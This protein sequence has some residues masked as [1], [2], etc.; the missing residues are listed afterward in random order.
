MTFACVSRI[1]IHVLNQCCCVIHSLCC[2]WTRS[3][4]FYLLRLRF[5]HAYLADLSLRLFLWQLLS[6]WWVCSLYLSLLQL[7]WSNLCLSSSIWFSLCDVDPLVFYLVLHRFYTLPLVHCWPW[8]NVCYV[9]GR[10]AHAQKV[11]RSNRPQ[12]VSKGQRG[13]SAI[14]IAK[15]ANHFAKRGTSKLCFLFFFFVHL[16]G[17]SRCLT[18]ALIGRSHSV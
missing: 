10:W 14:D 15:G 8:L 18:S 17:I 5:W 11:A 7:I 16:F 12:S 4:V 6:P 9:D 13:A 1:S 2:Y 3:L